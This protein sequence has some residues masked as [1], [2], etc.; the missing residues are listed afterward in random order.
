L[1][2][3]LFFANFWSEARQI[4]LSSSGSKS[5]YLLK[6][7]PEQKAKAKAESM[8][9][10]PCSLMWRGDIFQQTFRDIFSLSRLMQQ[11]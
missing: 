4:I 1:N 8:A 9:F 5:N 3:P 10:D 7:L 6:L 11:G 2:F